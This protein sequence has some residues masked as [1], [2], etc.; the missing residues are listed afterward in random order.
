VQA[1]QK[2]Q[3]TGILSLQLTNDKCV[4]DSMSVA[5]ARCK[6]RGRDL[7]ECGRSLFPQ[8]DPT[9]RRARPKL[10]THDPEEIKLVQNY[11][12][13]LAIQRTH[14]DSTA[15]MPLHIPSN[16]ALPQERTNSWE[17]LG[18]ANNPSLVS[19]TSNSEPPL[20]NEELMSEMVVERAGSD[21][22]SDLI[23]V[24][25]LDALFSLFLN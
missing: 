13:K 11:R 15:L 14:L 2:G 8:D 24:G 25:E 3:A 17:F 16:T 6:H 18:A 10:L 19:D 20:S 7:R 22:S 5:C 4:R 1:L 21:G 23:S 12:A 9:P